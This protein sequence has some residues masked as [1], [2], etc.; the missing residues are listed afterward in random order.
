MLGTRNKGCSLVPHSPGLSLRGR[1][2][3]PKTVVSRVT[4][5]A[6][7][8]DSAF[9]RHA[10]SPVTHVPPL[11]MMPA[12]RLFKTSVLRKPGLFKMLSII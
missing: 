7:V 4:P 1:L 5:A 8:A 9:V 10:G 3:F 11:G 2:N 12:R 6:D